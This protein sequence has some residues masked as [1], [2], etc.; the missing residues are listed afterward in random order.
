M[1]AAGYI[2]DVPVT[3]SVA[4]RGAGRKRAEEIAREF[5]EGLSPSQEYVDGFSSQLTRGATVT[6][7]SF[8]ASRE[9]SCEVLEELE[10]EP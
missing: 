6:E 8:E 5:A 2:I 7:V 3:L 10:A 4:V 9:D 1:R